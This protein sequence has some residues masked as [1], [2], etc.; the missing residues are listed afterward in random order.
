[1]NEKDNRE[2]NDQEIAIEDLS[3]ENAEASK[4]KGGVK[5]PDCLIASYQTTGHGGD[6]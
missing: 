3:A 2:T 5:L 1:M 6:L 4:V